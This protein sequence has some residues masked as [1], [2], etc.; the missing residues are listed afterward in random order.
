MGEK[1]YMV[2]FQIKRG[3]TLYKSEFFPEINLEPLIKTKKEAWALADKF[4]HNCGKYAV[5]V[6]VVDEN[7]K[8]TKSSTMLRRSTEYSGKC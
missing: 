5:N 1:G 4:I 8:P 6:Y 2:H 3:D 7:F